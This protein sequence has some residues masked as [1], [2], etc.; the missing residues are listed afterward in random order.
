M[1]DILVLKA[2]QTP[3]HTKGKV[4]DVAQHFSTD[5]VERDAE[6]TCVEDDAPA[7]VKAKL[8]GKTPAKHDEVGLALLVDKVDSI[9]ED[10]KARDI[11]VNKVIVVK[12]YDGVGVE[13][14]VW[15][16][17]KE[18]AQGGEGVAVAWIVMQKEGNVCRGE[19]LALKW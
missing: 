3:C 4:T 13:Y 10:A 18:P 14:S 12:V 5:G 6:L 16:R 9:K 8:V 1:I 2:Y 7:H 15:G 19:E 17:V 11:V